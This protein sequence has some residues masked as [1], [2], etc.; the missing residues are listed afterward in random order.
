MEDKTIEYLNKYFDKDFRVTPMAP[1]KYTL[2]DIENIEETLG[3]KFPEEYKAHILGAFPGMYVEII[4]K[5]WP[6]PKLYDVG[7]FWTFLYGIHTYSGS[8]N[9]EDW[10]RLEIIGKEFI[11]ETEIKAVPVLKIIGNEDLY[12]VNEE[13]KIVQYNHEENII[14]EIN[15]NFWELLDKELMELKE[16]KEKKIKENRKNKM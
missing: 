7:P 15:M 6:R 11:E 9:S 2:N 5:V 1:D 4:E 16:G 12:C 10:M 3:I 8:K 14:E 13:G